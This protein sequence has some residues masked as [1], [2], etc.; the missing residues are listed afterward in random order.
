MGD[1][2]LAALRARRM[3]EMQVSVEEG[4]NMRGVRMYGEEVRSR[5]EELFRN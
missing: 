2:E 4:A 5:G 1:D 3:A